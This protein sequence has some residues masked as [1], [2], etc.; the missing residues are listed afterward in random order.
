MYH[1]QG[2]NTLKWKQLHVYKTEFAC[3]SLMLKTWSLILALG[4]IFHLSS[5]SVFLEMHHCFE[6]STEIRETLSLLHYNTLVA[7]LILPILE[8]SL[9]LFFKVSCEPSVLLRLKTLRP[10]V[11]CITNWASQAPQKSSD[12]TFSYRTEKGLSSTNISFP[13]C[14]MFCKLYSS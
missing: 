12:L 8:I 6:T 2:K 13:R 3:D 1:I 4:G 5:I 10:G 9:S 11:A 7:N 14:K